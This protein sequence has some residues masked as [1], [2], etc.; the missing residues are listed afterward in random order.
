[1]K[2]GIVLGALACAFLISASAQ[3]EYARSAT[4]TKASTER[5]TESRMSSNVDIACVGK[6]A[7]TR[8]QALATGITALNT[9]VSSAYTKR[10]A[11]LAT[12]Y[13]KT[14]TKTVK[15]EVKSAW[16][17]FKK[18][19]KS[20]RTSWKSAQKN[21]WATFRSSTKSCKVAS[22]IGDGENESTEV[23]L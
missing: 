12:A 23:G 10:G 1:M 14:D 5:K 18:D 2:K 21:A 4:S 20:A 16:S 15:N 13:A 22:T 11:A 19:I 7:A 6:A 9:A 17:M 3:A 8:E